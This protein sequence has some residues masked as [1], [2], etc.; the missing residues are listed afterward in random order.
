MTSDVVQAQRRWVADQRAEHA[1]AAG[2]RPDRRVRGLVD[3]PGEE[4]AASSVRDS[5]STPSAA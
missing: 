4:A 5:L 2:K 1:A 3:A